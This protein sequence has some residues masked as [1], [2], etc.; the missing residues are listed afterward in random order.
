MCV[1]SL[2]SQFSFCFFFIIEEKVASFLACKT[3]FVYISR[4]K[5]Q[6][7]VDGAGGGQLAQANRSANR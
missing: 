2:S 6:R 3:T 4:T 5:L 7:M 1:P